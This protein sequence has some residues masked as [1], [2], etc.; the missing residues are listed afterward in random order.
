MDDRALII[1]SVV[2]GGSGLIALLIQRIKNPVNS[3]DARD[4]LGTSGSSEYFDPRDS[5]GTSVS[6]KYQESED[7]MRH[8]LNHW[9]N[10]LRGD[11]L[12]SDIDLMNHTSDFTNDRS[13]SSLTNDDSSL[14]RRNTFG[15]RKT[16][17]KYAK[18]V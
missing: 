17:R 2:V 10:Y 1:T 3:S 4:S 8:L 5:I 12:N 14:S 15:G 13:K 16:K 7:D 9:E 11:S 6:S 18:R